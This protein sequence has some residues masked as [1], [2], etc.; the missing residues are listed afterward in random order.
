[1]GKLFLLLST[2]LI[3][4]FGGQTVF[5]PLKLGFILDDILYVAG[6]LTQGE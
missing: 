1:M 4:A 3:F 6:P 2:E 5:F